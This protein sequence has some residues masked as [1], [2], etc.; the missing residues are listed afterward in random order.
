MIDPDL[1]TVGAAKAITD[2]FSK[3]I[4]A[5]A[6]RVGSAVFDRAKV[7]LEIGFTPFLKKTYER[8]KF[9]KTILDPFAPCDLEETYINVKLYSKSKRINLDDTDVI[10]RFLDGERFA[11]TG[12]AGCGKSM[13]MKLA[14]LRT[15]SSSNSVPLFFELRKLNSKKS[16]DIV[17]DIFQECS[18]PNSGVS[19][20]Q[21]KIA[22]KSG[23]IA[24]V[25]D[26]FDEIEYDSRRLISEQIKELMVDYP[27][28]PILISSRPDDDIFMSWSSVTV[29]DI[30]KF[31]RRQTRELIK[32]ARYDSG[33]KE[34]FLKS[35]ESSLFNTHG[36]FLKSPL[37]TIIMLFTYEEFAEIP[38]KMHAFYTR[39]FDT[40]FQKHDADKEQF[41]RKIKTRLSRE[42]FRLVLSCF[43]ALSYLDEK[44]FF[45]TSEV[46]KYLKSGIKYAENV[47][48]Q[49]SVGSSD[50]LAD[51][52]DAVCL[53]QQDGTNYVFVHRS[54]Q[55]Y[56]A[57]VFIERMDNQLLQKVVDRLSHRFND[58]VIPMAFD[59]S[60][61]K[62]EN[63]WVIPKLDEYLKLFKPTKSRNTGKVFSS[64]IASV[65][66]SYDP[67]DTEERN[68]KVRK[69]ISR[70]FDDLNFEMLGPLEAIFREYDDVFEW[71]QII[72]PTK[73]LTFDSLS[74]AISGNLDLRRKNAGNL[75][76]FLN[77]DQKGARTVWM[78][79]NERD[80]WWLNALGFSECFDE[81]HAG[82]VKVKKDILK[83][84]A[85]RST[86]LDD[87]LS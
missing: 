44:F 41:V 39:A 86:I 37:L 29:L 69:R 60:R 43:C 3:K 83:R 6:L 40:L 30:E 22:M 14:A 79:I 26:G 67:D 19:F 76:D 49:I 31:D 63:N 56:F 38:N 68:S 54:F 84:S 71:A 46:D 5:A 1:V 82:L 42:D 48:P 33:V 85:R 59:L 75:R 61:E 25:L 51:L 81:I 47:S 21:F 36:D 87:L 24:L 62:L 9:Y 23:L 17:H 34:R 2:D 52:R 15:F 11:V 12:L 77:S 27:E 55:E 4:S 28:C 50:F 13:F 10:Y 35:L 80:S 32:K 73:D 58:N 53:I 74:M 65:R 16:K 72:K 78:T 8:C 64:F 66:F 70:I 7:K 18:A 45:S 20:T 57:A